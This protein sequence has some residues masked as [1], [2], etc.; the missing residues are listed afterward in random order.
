MTNEF[1]R[2]KIDHSISCK[3]F[4]GEVDFNSGWPK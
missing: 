1:K 2:K 4:N 3:R